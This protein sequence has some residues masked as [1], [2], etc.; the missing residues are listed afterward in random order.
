[1]LFGDGEQRP[2]IVEDGAQAALAIRQIAQRA[3]QRVRA[4]VQAVRYGAATSRRALR[5]C[6]LDA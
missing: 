6:Q 5:R 2:R 3:L 1:V 4:F